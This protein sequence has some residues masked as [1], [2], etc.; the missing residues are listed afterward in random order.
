M[1]GNC[2]YPHLLIN[3]SAG[4]I[5]CKAAFKWVKVNGRCLHRRLDWVISLNLQPINPC[6]CDAALPCSLA[7]GELSKR[8]PKIS[9]SVGVTGLAAGCLPKQA[10][11]RLVLCSASVASASLL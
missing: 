6:I 8:N 11:L 1:S 10:L 5:E 2:L 9:Q 4:V 7:A 3:K